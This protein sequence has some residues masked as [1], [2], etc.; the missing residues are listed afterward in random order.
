MGAF[1]VV[2]ETMLSGRSELPFGTFVLMMLPIHLAIGLVEGFITAGV[3][4]YVRAARPGILESIVE[5]KPLSAEIKVKNIVL[6]FLAIAIITGGLMSWFASANPDGLEWS[7]NKIYGKPELP[8]NEK[9]IGSVMKRI[10]EKTAF[11]P[12][13]S[14]RKT[15][16]AEK[17]P[18]V[19]SAWP[20]VEAGTSLSGLAGS[21]IVICMVVFIGFS[22]RIMRKKP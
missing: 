20:N 21:I 1:S 9:G 16:E 5:S 2:I 13:Y 8:E 17:S 6:A 19:E 7:I 14:F 18:Q 22:I 15:E 11:L 12:D 3:I 10:Q 4:S